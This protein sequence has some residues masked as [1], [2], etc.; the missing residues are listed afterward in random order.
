MLLSLLNVAIKRVTF[1]AFQGPHLV[2]MVVLDITL[3]RRSQFWVLLVDLLNELWHLLPLAYAK[4]ISSSRR[5]G[6]HF[7]V[8]NEK[9]PEVDAS[10]SGRYRN[11]PRSAD[12][13]SVLYVLLL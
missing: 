10:V 12:V 8:G 4:R 2:V 11:I 5:F 3:E 13:M 6:F 7:A 9:L 1:S